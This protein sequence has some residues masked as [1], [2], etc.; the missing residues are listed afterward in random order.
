MYRFRL[1]LDEMVS[2]SL[3]D[4][5]SIE[6]V[7]ALPIRDRGMLS[8]ADHVVWR[9]AQRE[10][11]TVVTANGRDFAKLATETKHAGLVLI[12]NGGTR[13]E[14]FSYIK[15]AW[16]HVWGH[17]GFAATFQDRIATVSENRFVLIESQQTQAEVVPIRR[18]MH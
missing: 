16:T 8:A 7:D 6:G 10:Q 12:P 3:K 1:L 5:C 18:K 11:R 15:A 9:F 2:P 14:Q 4:R 17:N 13:D